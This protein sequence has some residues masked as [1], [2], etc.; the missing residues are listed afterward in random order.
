MSDVISVSTGSNT[1]VVRILLKSVKFIILSYVISFILLL[2]LALV[3]VYTDVSETISGPAVNIIT[4]S[5]AFVSSFLTAGNLTSKGWICGF[6]SGMLNIML[7][8]AAGSLFTSS[9]FFTAHKMMFMLY[10]GICGAVGGIIGVNVG[11]N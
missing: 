10:G 2:V 9:A 11:K 5:G 4:L 6:L 1:G 3:I 8:F 7:L